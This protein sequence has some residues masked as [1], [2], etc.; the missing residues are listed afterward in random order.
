MPFHVAFKAANCSG[1]RPRTRGFRGCSG[2]LRGLAQLPSSRSGGPHNAQSVQCAAV[3]RNRHLVIRKVSRRT[4]QSTSLQGIRVLKRVLKSVTGS[5]P[6][7]PSL[8]RFVLTTSGWPEPRSHRAR[9]RPRAGRC[10]RP[11]RI[12]QRRLTETARRQIAIYTA[13]RFRETQILKHVF[14]VNVVATNAG[15]AVNPNRTADST[16]S[17]VH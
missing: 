8:S 16:F 14:A 9:T 13:V 17:P 12:S 5:T 7:R 1:F 4:A 3:S 6:R 15:H 11:H 10:D 2:P